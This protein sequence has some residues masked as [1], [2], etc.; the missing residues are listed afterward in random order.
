LGPVNCPELE[1][2]T[3]DGNC[4]D[5]AAFKASPMPKNSRDAVAA[6][7]GWCSEQRVRHTLRASSS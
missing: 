6:G 3:A 7:T 2:R 5:D 1:L 4:G